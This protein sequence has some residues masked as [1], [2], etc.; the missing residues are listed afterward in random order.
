MGLSAH[1]DGV[2]MVKQLSERHFRAIHAFLLWVTRG[3]SNEESGLVLNMSR[4]TVKR[5][6]EYVFS[7]LGVESRTAVAMMAV[8]QQQVAKG[9]LD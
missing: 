9:R 5:H 4:S 6:L 7:K 8:T 1:P 2:R 3:K